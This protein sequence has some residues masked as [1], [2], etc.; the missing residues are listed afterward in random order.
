MSQ[1]FPRGCALPGVVVLCLTAAMV[2]VGPLPRGAAVRGGLPARS[3]A[4]SARIFED[5]RFAGGATL[6]DRNWALTVGHIFAGAGTYTLRFG[7]VDNSDDQDSIANIRTIDGIVPHP[8]LADVAMVHFATP[9]PEGTWIPPLATQAPPRYSAARLYGW[10]PTGEVLNRALGLVL[11]QAAVEQ[12]AELRS[13]FPAF[14]RAFPPSIEPMT[15]NL[16][17]DGGDSGSG[18]FSADG[19]LIGVHYASATYGYFDASGDPVGQNYMATYNQPVWLHRE[20]IRRVISG[21]GSSNAAPRDELKRRRL[22]GVEGNTLPMTLPPQ[23]DL[24]DPGMTSCTSPVLR[25]A[26]G[27]LLGA[28]NYRGTALARCVAVERNGC[29]FDGVAA[30]AGTSARMRLG[31]SSAPNAPG[32]RE[33]MVWCTADAAFPEAGSPTRPVLRVS[34]TNADPQKSPIGYGWWDVTPDQVGTGTGRTLLDTSRLT[35]C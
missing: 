28:G 2:W 22:T 16:V 4:A 23:T 34:F 7:V 19:T 21:A 12:A 9:V 11:D 25:W 15:V 3:S 14:A 17:A 20:W 8:Q 27:V 29:S 1:W 26:R 31:P 6:V 24:C 32:T 35:P 5:G 13:G 33:V 18:I 30:A 10:G